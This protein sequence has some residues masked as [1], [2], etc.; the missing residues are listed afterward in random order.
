MESGFLKSF[1]NRI[2]RAKL[3]Y[4]SS[5]NP[6]FG[7]I[8]NKETKEWRED[9]E[10]KE[11][12]E[13]IADRF[14]EG[15]SLKNLSIEFN[16]NYANLIKILK[17]RTGDIW[18]QR[19]K[20][21]RLKV[22]VT[23]MTPVPRLLSEEKI[24]AVRARIA[25]N[26]TITHGQILNKYLL[27]H[28]IS[29]GT[30]GSPLFGQTNRHRRKYYRHPRDRKITCSNLFNAIPADII[31]DPVIVHLY[32]FF[33]NKTKM[34]EAIKE[35]IPDRRELKKLPMQKERH[36]KQLKKVRKEKDRLINA[37]AKGIISDEEAM[38]KIEKIRESENLLI[39]DIE[40]IQSKLKNVPSKEKIERASQLTRRHIEHLYRG[41]RKF[42]EMSFDEKRKLAQYAFNS[43]DS[44]GKRS[45]VYVE[46]TD[47]VNYP[48][49][50]TL[51]GA[52][53]HREDKL[54]MRSSDARSILGIEDE[55]IDPFKL[56]MQC[57][58]T[59]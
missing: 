9:K 10:K 1:K 52:L 33:G 28:M 47:R 54:P 5:G 59:A 56:N 25:S 49:Y 7:R 11:T 14:L 29:C 37:I 17:D 38:Q 21:D 57:Q 2:R 50:F 34:E 42:S 13:V 15:E 6:P 43:V 22:D 23:V 32:Q 20:C 26:R 39:A 36:E 27:S 18:P 51:K 35:A 3:G 4:P 44:N 24:Q 48:W 53:I 16:M 31:D 55:S 8:W 45:G 30:C 12:I 58:V 41:C 19:F 40:S 46:K